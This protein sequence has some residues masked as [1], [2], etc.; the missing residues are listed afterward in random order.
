MQDSPQPEEN[1]PQP[2]EDNESTETGPSS[3]ELKS[4]MKAFKKRLKLARLDADSG[5]GHGPTSGGR[6]SG[7][8][9]IA[10]PTQYPQEVWDELVRRGRLKYAGHGLY[11]KV[12]T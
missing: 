2:S 3:A 5:L 10:P 12:D 7:I 11:E 8:V 6:D 1:P 4:A 9:A